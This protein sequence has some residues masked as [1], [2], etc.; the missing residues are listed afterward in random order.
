MAKKANTQGQKLSL[1]AVL[2][3]LDNRDFGFYER[4]TDE[5]RKGYSPFLLMRYMSSLSPQSP[6]QSYAVLATNDLVNLGFFGLGKHP[7]LQHKLMC[8]AG[9]GRKQYRPYVGAKNAKSKTKVVDE[10][11]Q[12]LYPSINTEELSLLKS[13]L[14]KES[15]R[16]L[17][18][19]AGLSDS[20]LKE[21]V[22]D[23]KKLER[24]S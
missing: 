24:D 20:E 17:G 3:A 1:D 5:E 2:Q 7:E 21:L 18:K 15:L 4:L 12:G 9:T 19:D 22:E 8:L 16:Q 6:M 23:G 13:Q 11:L 10:F 14:D